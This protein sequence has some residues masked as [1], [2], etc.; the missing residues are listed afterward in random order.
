MLEEQHDY[1]KR[2]GLL[3]QLSN[4]IASV[5]EKQV[6]Y[7]KKH[8]RLDLQPEHLDQL[9]L[10]QI[11][12]LH[13]RHEFARDTLQHA[14]KVV[15]DRIAEGQAELQRLFH[16]F[17]KAL[18][19]T[20]GNS[21]IKLHIR[22]FTNYQDY[23]RFLYTERPAAHVD[24]AIARLPPERRQA[25]E[26]YRQFDNPTKA[27]RYGFNQG[28]HAVP[29]C[30]ETAYSTDN[31]RMAA[32]M[33][34]GRKDTDRG[35][36]KTA[37]RLL[38]HE[39]QEERTRRGVQSR[40]PFRYVDDWF[41]KAIVAYDAH[42]VSVLFDMIYPRLNEFGLE[43]DPRRE[44]RR[45]K[46][47]TYDGGYQEPGVDNH[48]QYGGR[49]QLIQ[50]KVC[51]IGLNRRYE[52]VLTDVANLLVDQREHVRFRQQQADELKKLCGL[53]R[54]YRKR[55]DEFMERGRELHDL[56]PEQRHRILVPDEYFTR[57]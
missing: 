56:L 5:I 3:E 53:R 16:R 50:L 19:K 30:L 55:F 40:K 44:K 29:V 17:Q 46:D 2:D 7:G 31:T 47:G 21:R 15:V 20:N 32:L 45:R 49:D 52:I 42:S 28:L 22:P 37:F 6:D 43:P 4:P 9:T 13:M 23:L 48:Y 27:N 14:Q 24:P 39:V 35:N 26:Y 54:A 18:L 10:G 38:E 36:E 33:I 51:P 34:V 57:S 12:A 41:R 1:A 25:I 11:L 8:C